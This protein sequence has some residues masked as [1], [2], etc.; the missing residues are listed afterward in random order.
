MDKQKDMQQILDLLNDY[1]N[2]YDIDS[3]KHKEVYN[4]ILSLT[5]TPATTK[6]TKTTKTKK[7][8]STEPKKDIYDTWTDLIN[9]GMKEVQTK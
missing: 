7:A 2:K 1:V 6:T 4:A 5:T 8:Q 9:S 3:K